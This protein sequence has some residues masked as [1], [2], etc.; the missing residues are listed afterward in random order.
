MK[1]DELICPNCQTKLNDLKSHVACP[2]CHKEY[3]V[4]INE[5]GRS[6]FLKV[7]IPFNLA[8]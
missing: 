2:G 6:Q 3:Q 4:A 5:Q 7:F 1:R 8:L